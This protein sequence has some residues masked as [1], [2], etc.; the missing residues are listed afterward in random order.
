MKMY[1]AGE[2][3]YGSD[4][5]EVRSPFDGSVVDTIPWAT[6]DE[7]EAALASAVRGAKAMAALPASRRSAILLRTAALLRERAEDFAQILT[8]EMG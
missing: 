5:R 8:R 1:I 6:T 3:T 7:V 2:W 4:T